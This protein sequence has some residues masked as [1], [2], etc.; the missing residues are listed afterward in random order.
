[1]V[2][3]NQSNHLS[4]TKTNMNLNL[5][6]IFAGMG[7]RGGG[8]LCRLGGQGGKKQPMTGEE[9]DEVGS[10]GGLIVVHPLLDQG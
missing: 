4:T 8:L 5:G 1:M 6:N 2:H 9:N 3:Q 7:G 10:E